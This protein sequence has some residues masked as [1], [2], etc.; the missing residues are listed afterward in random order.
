MHVLVYI[1][2]F[3]SILSSQ[4]VAQQDNRDRMSI[5]VLEGQQEKEFENFDALYDEISKHVK[6]E[7]SAVKDIELLSSQLSLRKEVSW[8]SDIKHILS[9]YNALQGDT[10]KDFH[11]TMLLN[12]FG[13][14]ISLLSSVCMSYPQDNKAALWYNVGALVGLGCYAFQLWRMPFV[15][16]KLPD[17]E[18]DTIKKDEIQGVVKKLTEKP[19][20]VDLVKDIKENIFK[21]D[22][23]LMQRVFSVI[24]WLCEEQ[25]VNKYFLNSVMV[26]A[27]GSCAILNV[28]SLLASGQEQH[29]FVANAVSMVCLFLLYLNNSGYSGS[30]EVQNINID[31]MS[32]NADVA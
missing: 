27:L 32:E 11:I 6:P 21:N 26:A 20:V 5:Q 13:I 1:V 23:D 28:L 3:F 31:K 24:K 25:D 2:Y 29:V 10:V 18:F 19:L 17:T 15:A 16:K 7:T 4:I 12:G 22:S 14:G 30:L 9:I 8:S